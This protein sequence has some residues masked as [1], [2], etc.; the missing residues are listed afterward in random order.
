MLENTLGLV[1]VT[2]TIMFLTFGLIFGIMK[3]KG[4][5]LIVGYNFKPK[6]E[7]RKYDEKQM[8]KDMRNLFFIYGL[9]FL[10]G[11]VATY[12]WGKIW[13]WISFM[14]WLIYFFKNLHID[15]EK[16]FGKYKKGNEG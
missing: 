5:S 11:T 13:F 10:V 4:A 2:M 8:S 15:D 1:G 12:I 7:R 9:I 3:E 16:A 14:I 6:K